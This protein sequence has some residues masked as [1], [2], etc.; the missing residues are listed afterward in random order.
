MFWRSGCCREKQPAV[1]LEESN[2][3]LMC[4]TAGGAFGGYVKGKMKK[5]NLDVANLGLDG[6]IE[7]PKHVLA[8][9][10]CQGCDI[11]SGGVIDVDQ[12]DCSMSHPAGT[13]IPS[14]VL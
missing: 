2:G 9:G 12:N 10:L 8:N 6:D 13:L 4:I 7:F 3:R 11:L 5:E 14:G 1:A